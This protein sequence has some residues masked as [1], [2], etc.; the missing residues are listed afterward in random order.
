[1]MVGDMATTSIGSTSPVKGWTSI[2]KSGGLFFA[3]ERFI[4]FEIDEEYLKVA[5]PHL[6]ENSAREYG[7]KNMP[8]GV[9]LLT[10][11]PG[12]GGCASFARPLQPKRWSPSGCA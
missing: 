8:P 11:L 3:V 1:M 5:E 12:W 6:P 7:F 4:G 2:E 9:A 10:P